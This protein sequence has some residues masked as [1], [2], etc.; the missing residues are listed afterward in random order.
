MEIWRNTLG[1][2]TRPDIKSTQ[3]PQTHELP[4]FPLIYCKGGSAGCVV[5]N[6]ED[7]TVETIL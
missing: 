5:P 6:V 4:R 3:Q 7:Y 1:A 2:R